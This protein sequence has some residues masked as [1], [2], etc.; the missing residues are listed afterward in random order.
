MPRFRVT[1]HTTG[2]PFSREVEAASAEAAHETAYTEAKKSGGVR[3]T[4]KD[5]LIAIEG[6]QIAAISVEAEKG[7]GGTS[8]RPATIG[9]L[10]S[11]RR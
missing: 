4:E 7:Q 11:L 3:Y 5:V 1:Y 8:D 6:A 9:L 2:G 10:G